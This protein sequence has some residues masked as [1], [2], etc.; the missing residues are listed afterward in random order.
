MTSNVDFGKCRMQNLK[1]TNK[2]VHILISSN[3]NIVVVKYLFPLSCVNMT[4]LAYGCCII[5]KSSDPLKELKRN[6]MQNG[7]WRKFRITH[8]ADKRKSNGFVRLAWYTSQISITF[9][10]HFLNFFPRQF[11]LRTTRHFWSY[12]ARSF[13]GLSPLFSLSFVESAIY[14]YIR[15][16]VHSQSCD[17]WTHGHGG[18]LSHACVVSALLHCTIN[19]S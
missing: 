15:L 14:I 8:H 17:I 19:D 10:K 5:P 18:H 2:D 9:F 11:T 13:D 16:T 7:K 6:R 12:H 1:R 4:R 3:Q